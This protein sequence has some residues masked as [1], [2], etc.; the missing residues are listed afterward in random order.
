MA[1]I[2]ITDTDTHL[3]ETDSGTVVFTFKILS[4]ER[5][6]ACMGQPVHE[7]LQEVL[8]EVSGLEIEQAGAVV[9]APQ[10]K[11]A[12]L[13]YP[14]LVTWVNAEYLS[15]WQKKAQMPIFKAAPVSGQA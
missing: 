1:R 10:V 8:V 14:P 9:S 2:T 11:A 12:L 4:H 13:T 3:A 6:T 15:F 7:M 5:F